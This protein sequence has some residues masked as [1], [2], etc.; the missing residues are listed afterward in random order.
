MPVIS[1]DACRGVG[2]FHTRQVF[3]TEAELDRLH[4]QEGVPAPWMDSQREEPGGQVAELMEF[5]YALRTIGDRKRRILFARLE[6]LTFIEI[7]AALFKGATAQAMENEFAEIMRDFPAL[8]LAFPT[9]GMVQGAVR[10]RSHNN[11]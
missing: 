1:S 3:T 8:E 11:G 4:M 5:L 6:D 9:R 10:K 2:P 7:G